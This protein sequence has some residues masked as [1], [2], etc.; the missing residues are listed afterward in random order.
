VRE[1]VGD[2]VASASVTG[3]L[4]AVGIGDN[5]VRVET[6]AAEEGA[7]LKEKV[8]IEEDLSSHHSVS[9]PFLLA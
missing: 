2:V 6:E 4:G 8:C 1:S 7:V 5:V 9:F 3:E